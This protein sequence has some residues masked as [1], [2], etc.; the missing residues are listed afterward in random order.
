MSI[1]SKAFLAT[2][3]E[4]ERHINN[5]DSIQYGFDNGQISPTD[6]EIET[7]VENK[8]HVQAL[9]KID[10]GAE[11]ADDAENARAGECPVHKHDTEMVASMLDCPICGNRPPKEDDPRD[12]SGIIKNFLMKG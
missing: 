12:F 5:L 11:D 4:W 6:F 3:K 2:R 1:S 7:E 9:D 10:G 8:R